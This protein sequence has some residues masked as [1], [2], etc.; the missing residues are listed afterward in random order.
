MRQVTT[1]AFLL[2][3]MLSTTAVAQTPGDGETAEVEDVVSAAV[4]TAFHLKLKL[5]AGAVGAAGGLAVGTLAEMLVCSACTPLLSEA[6]RL[7]PIVLLAPLAVATLGFLM[8]QD[9]TL[10]SALL[11]SVIG[12]AA[13]LGIGLAGFEGE[14]FWLLLPAA[15]A[16]IAYEFSAALNH[17]DLQALPFVA[18][19]GGGLVVTCTF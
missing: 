16:A 19:G 11:G 10:S 2:I 5:I 3:A 1:V 7:T 9:G 17:P 4:V 18:P 13:A 15:G 14:L 8:K 12:A 6:V